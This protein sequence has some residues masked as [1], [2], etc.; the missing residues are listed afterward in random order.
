MKD[1]ELSYF[2]TVLYLWF[3]NRVGI[4][5]KDRGT[6]NGR[7]MYIKFAKSTGKLIKEQQ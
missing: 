2:E 6:S 5:A 3:Y 1:L 7:P 4:S